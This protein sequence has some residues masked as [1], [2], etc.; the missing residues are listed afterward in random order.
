MGL[1]LTTLRSRVTYSF[2]QASQV[3]P[4]QIFKTYE[5]QAPNRTYIHIPI[6]VPDSIIEVPHILNL[7]LS[8]AH[9][10]LWHPSS[11]PRCI[12][13]LIPTS[14]WTPIPSLR[15]TISLTLPYLV[16]ETLAFDISGLPVISAPTSR[17]CYRSETQSFMYWA[18][19][20]NYTLH[21][22]SNGTMLPLF[23]ES[24]DYSWP[25]NNRKLGTWTPP[26]HRKSVCILL[27]PQKLKC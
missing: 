3:P 5:Q 26:H 11:L 9:Y 14:P 25:L 8:L 17:H 15:W 16:V 19:L 27:T 24:S 12:P 7:V 4:N 6:L 2:Q 22:N 21:W 23:K 10:H 18:L 13:S 20:E 1:K